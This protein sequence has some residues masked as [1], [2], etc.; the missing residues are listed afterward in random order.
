MK[1]A[2]QMAVERVP[3]GAAMAW[4]LNLLTDFIRTPPYY[5]MISI[6]IASCL[7]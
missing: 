3:L 4:K 7:R 1:E 2:W 5:L 6:L